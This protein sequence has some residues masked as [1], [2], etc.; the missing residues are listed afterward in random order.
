MLIFTSNLKSL[1]APIVK[2]KNSNLSIKSH[3]SYIVLDS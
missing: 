1:S 2:S 3:F